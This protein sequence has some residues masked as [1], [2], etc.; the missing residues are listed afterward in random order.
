MWHTMKHI[1]KR[2]KNNYV[3]DIKQWQDHRYDP[4]YF[5]GGKIP[6]FIKYF[7][8]NKFIGVLYILGGSVYLSI[9]IIFIGQMI[10][11][12]NN[13]LNLIIIVFFFLLFGIIYFL[14]GLR[15]IRRKKREK[16]YS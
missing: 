2:E 3:D 5:T 13:V 7:R 4:A 12:R 14:I 8:A 1:K 10:I 15:H 9:V 16:H 6:P 11:N